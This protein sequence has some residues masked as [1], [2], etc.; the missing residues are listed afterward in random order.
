M[1]AVC[2]CENRLT[3]RHRDK[4]RND[5]L[6]H[7]FHV[8]ISYKCMS[9]SKSNG[10]GITHRSL[11]DTD[12][13]LWGFFWCRMKTPSCVQIVFEMNFKKSIFL[14]EIFFVK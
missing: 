5:C 8:K 11:I 13:I 9:L 3:K 4:V 10:V 12:F 7:R 6:L 14:C 2:L 1:Q